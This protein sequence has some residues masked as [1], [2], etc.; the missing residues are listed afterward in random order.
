MGGIQAS[1]APS[2]PAVLDS[3]AP[4]AP[5]P[6]GF[7]GHLQF[8]GIWKCLQGQ[9]CFC[10]QK[11]SFCYYSGTNAKTFSFSFRHRGYSIYRSSKFSCSHGRGFGLI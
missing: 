4:Q 7:E 6:K 10:V 5:S 2:I 3:P 9:L 1:P 8:L 11:D